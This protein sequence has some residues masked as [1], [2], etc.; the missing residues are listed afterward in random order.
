MPTD[1]F[2]GVRFGS[3]SPRSV[4]VKRLAAF[5]VDAGRV[6]SALA[7]QQLS[8]RRRPMPRP[9]RPATGRPTAAAS[10]QRVDRGAR[11]RVPV[12]LA[13]AADG[14]VRQRVVP[15]GRRVLIGADAVEL[16][17]D[18]GGGNPVLEDRADVELARR[19]AALEGDERYPG[20]A[21]AARQAGGGDRVGTERFLLVGAADDAALRTSV[22]LAAL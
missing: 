13:A 9:A 22:L 21:A 1:A 11:S 5:A 4:I 18:V 14:E 12:A 2:V 8:V 20:A 19:R 17:A 7:G 15:A 10:R 6:V 3:S 16:D